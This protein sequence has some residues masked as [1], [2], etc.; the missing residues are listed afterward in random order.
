MMELIVIARRQPLSNWSDALALARSDQT[1]RIDGRIRR[2]ALCP[3]LAK[4]GAS[5]SESSA[6]QS[7]IPRAPQIGAQSLTPP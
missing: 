3:S 1:S 5:Q 6:L 7:A 2:R 4:N